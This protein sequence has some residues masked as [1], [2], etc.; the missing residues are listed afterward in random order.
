MAAVLEQK[1][2]VTTSSPLY[3]NLYTFL[4]GHPGLGKSRAIKSVMGFAR[5]VPDIHIGPTSLTMASLVDL[6]AESKRQIIQLPNPMIEY[7]TLYIAPDELSAF[8]QE[9]KGNELIPGL[10]TFYDTDSPYGQHRRT[11]GL[12]LKIDRP[13]LNILTGT[14]PANI[15]KFIPESAWEDG[16]TSRIIFIYAD[17]QPKIDVFKAKVREMPK[18][19][20]DDLKLINSI[21]GQIGWDEAYAEQM[22][23]WKSLGYPPVPNHPKLTHYCTRRFAHMIKLSMVA[24]IDRGEA[25]LSMSKGDFDR[26]YNWLCEAEKEMGK[27]FTAVSGSADSKAM[28]EIAF[29]VRQYP[30]G[31]SEHQLVG[32]ARTRVTYANSIQ[33]IL[34][35]MQQSGMIKCVALDPRTKLRVFTSNSM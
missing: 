31:V 9:Y 14:T 32:F 13:Q 8:M 16:F 28:D 1:V 20:L 12:K 6:L 4:V 11:T 15:M 26:A 10:T 2:W 19:M 34:E 35:V 25:I 18:D 22:Q 24:C 17:S 27:I 5:E 7:N 21:V 30:N 23:G 3:P 29:F 33:K